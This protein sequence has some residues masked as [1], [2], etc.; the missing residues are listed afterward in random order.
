MGYDRRVVVDF[1]DNSYDISL[2]KGRIILVAHI[3]QGLAGLSINSSQENDSEYDDGY[4]A[5]PFIQTTHISNTIIMC[6]W[7]VS[8]L[9][10]A[11]DG[12]TESGFNEA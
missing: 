4:T 9:G 6:I 3:T 7:G 1:T 11:G 12:I 5:V 10:E 8:T 2:T